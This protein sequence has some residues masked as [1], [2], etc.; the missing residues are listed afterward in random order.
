M[1]HQSLL[2]TIHTEIIPFIFKPWLILR[3]FCEASPLA[4]SCS[5][6]KNTDMEDQTPQDRAKEKL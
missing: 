5:V 6:A 4:L 3:C 2:S 1:E